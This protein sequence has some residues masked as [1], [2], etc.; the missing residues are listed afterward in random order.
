MFFDVVVQ[1]TDVV[2]L[3]EFPLVTDIGSA[4]VDGGLQWLR[5]D[6]VNLFT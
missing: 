5:G 6:V 3:R 2:V 1:S 4:G